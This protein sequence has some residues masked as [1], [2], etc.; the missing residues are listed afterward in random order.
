MQSLAERGSCLRRAGE[1]ERIEAKEELARGEL[2][3]EELSRKELARGE[4]GSCHTNT[5]RGG[6]GEGRSRTFE[7]GESGDC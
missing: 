7:E 1:E 2:G 3:R 5:C 4:L 6:V